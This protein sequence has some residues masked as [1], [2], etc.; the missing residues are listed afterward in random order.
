MCVCV[1]GCLCG[2]AYPTNSEDEFFVVV[3]LEESV[4][5]HI[6]PIKHQNFQETTVSTTTFVSTMEND[7]NICVFMSLKVLPIRLAAVK[8]IFLCIKTSDN[9]DDGEDEGD[10][11]GWRRNMKKVKEYEDEGR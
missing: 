7:L 5:L 11:R 4:V 6:P 9:E 3:V 2:A 1:F 8:C 10:D